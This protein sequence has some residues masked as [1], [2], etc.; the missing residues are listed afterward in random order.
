MSVSTKDSVPFTNA[1]AASIGGVGSLILSPLLYLIYLP[2][3]L[4]STLPG[5]SRL[6]SLS[7][8]IF[9]L[10][11]ILFPLYS[12][13]I[14]LIGSS[15]LLNSR[16]DVGEIDIS[17]ASF[18]GFLGGIFFIPGGV[19]GYFCVRLLLG[20]F[21]IIILPIWTAIVRGV[22]WVHVKLTENWMDKGHSEI[23]TELQEVP[24]GRD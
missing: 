11:V 1:S 8:R 17:D 12:T 6:Q 13:L 5:V 21:N 3:L 22:Q 19:A 7:G 15:V 18:A 24:P 23:N 16:V 14:G 4:S 9:F 2:N 10:I 20:V